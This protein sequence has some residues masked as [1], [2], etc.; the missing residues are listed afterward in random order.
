MK[1]QT[2]CVQGSDVCMSIIERVSMCVCVCVC[3]YHVCVCVYGNVH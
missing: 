2:L 1:W 3:M